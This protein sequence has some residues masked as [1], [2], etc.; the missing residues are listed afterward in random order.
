M[1]AMS[2]EHKCMRT[3]RVNVW[4]KQVGKNM[5]KYFLYLTIC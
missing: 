1:L 3:A 4:N 5:R 2:K